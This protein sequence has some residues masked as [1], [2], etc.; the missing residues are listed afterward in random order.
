MA[1]GGLYTIKVTGLLDDSQIIRK[2]KAIEKRMGTMY[3]G[4]KGKNGAA[5]IGETGKAAEKTGKQ[6]KGAAKGVNTYAGSV[7]KAG[8]TQKRFG[9]TTLDIT[10]KVIQFGATTAVIRGVTSGMGDMVRQVFE[11][12]KSLTEFKKVSTLSGKALEDYTNQAYE[13]GKQTAKTGVEMLDAATQFKKMGYDEKTSLQLATTATMFQNIADAEISAGDAALF[14]NSQMKAFSGEFSRMSTEGEKAQKVIDSVNEVANNYAVGSNDLQQALTKTS[15]AM[16]TFGNSFDQ[17]LGIMTAGTEIMVGMPSQVARGWR[18]IAANISKAGEAGNTWSAAAGKVNITMKKQNGEIKNT[19]EFLKDLYK[20]QKGVSKGWNQLNKDE[21]TAIALELAGKNNQEKF[22]AVMNNFQTAID[23]TATSEKS[24]GSAMRENARYMES[25]EGHVQALQSAWSRFS[26]AMIKS[27]VLK[28]VLDGL[29]KVVDFLSTDTGATLVKTTAQL[30][31]LA[32]AIR[33][34]TG[35]GSL[36]LLPFKK[37]ISLFTKFGKA[38]KV[39]AAGATAVKGAEVGATAGAVGLANIFSKIGAI[40]TNP[41]GLIA[42]ML[43]LGAG[44][45]Y[46]N[47]KINQSKTPEAQ[48]EK[49]H[50]KLGQLQSKYDEVT[51][52]ID[53]LHKK[54]SEG[55]LTSSEEAQLNALESEREAIQENIELYKQLEK[56]QKTASARTPDT[57]V[58]KTDKVKGKQRPVTKASPLGAMEKQAQKDAGAVDLLS[59]K[60]VIYEDKVK[61]VAEA[62]QK[63][64]KARENAVKAAQSGDPN[65]M[66][67]A[68][69]KLTKALDEQEVA[70]KDVNKAFKDMNKTNKELKE[71]YGSQERMPD[72]IRKSSEAVDKMVA[73][74]KSF[75]K[76]KEK[77]GEKGVDFTGLSGAAL[78]KTIDDMKNLGD[79]IGITVDE[80]GKLQRVNF[81]TMSSSMQQMGYTAEETKSALKMLGEQHPEA[82]FEIEGVDVAGK[83]IDTVLEYLDK[84]DG[85]DAEA[86]MEINGS[87]VAVSDIKD[88]QTLM[89]IINGKTS[90]ASVDL[91]GGEESANQMETVTE[92]GEQF[93]GRTFSGTADVNAAPATAKI[94]QVNQ[95]EIKEKTGII[96]GNNNPFMK[97]VRGANAAKVNDKNATISASLSSGFWGVINKAKAALSSVG[98]AKGTPSADEGFAE[99]NELGYEYIRDVKTGNLRVANGGK[100]GVTYLNKGDTV[101]T[102]GQSL[103]MKQESKEPLPQFAK[104]KKGKKKAQEAYN[105]RRDKIREKYDNAVDDLEYKQDLKHL[106]DEWLAKK[107]QEKWNKY[108]K[109]LKKYN[110]SKK[111][112][113]WKKKY[114]GFKIA[115]SLGKKRK[116]DLKL[117]KENARYDAY[118]DAMERE[119]GDVGLGFDIDGERTAG[120][121]ASSGREDRY[122]E[123][124]EVKK[125]RERLRKLKNKHKISAEDYKKYMDDLYHAY[126]DSQMKMYEKDKITADEMKQI[127]K[128]Q[129]AEQRITWEEYYEALEDIEDREADKARDKIEE[130]LSSV[131]WLSQSLEDVANTINQVANEAE[132][133]SKEVHDY[134]RDL[135]QDNLD[136][137]MNLYQYGKEVYS[138]LKQAV[139]DYYHAG[140]LT[141]KEYYSAVQDLASEAMAKEQERLEEK[142]DKNNNTY[143]LARQYVER[144]I[145]LLEK[146]N[147]ELDE[148]NELIEL[149]NDLE[150]AKSRRVRIYREGVGF[151]YEQDREAIEEATKALEQYKK[152]QDSPELK[153]WKEILSLFE[154]QDTVAGMKELENLIGMT[155]GQAFG[156][157]GTSLYAWEQYLKEN[158]ATELGMSAL[159]R[160]LDKVEYYED[161]LSRL[162][163]SGQISES[164]ISAYIARNRYASGTLSTPAGFAR[165]AEQGYEIGVFGAGDAVIPHNLS[166]NLM[167]WGKMSPLEYANSTSGDSY[168]YQFDKLVLPNVQN[169]NDF[170]RELKNLPNRA[171]QFSGGRA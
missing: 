62:E 77:G 125:E 107:M 43:A 140:Y 126:V 7:E 1:G 4:G 25:L 118:T 167:E 115:K 10:K 142:Q 154:E 19:Y 171:L 129:V 55:G 40:L 46:V 120:R 35:V 69:E 97:A 78:D 80:S 42:G 11:L 33:L 90:V 144:Q 92:K 161:I 48:Y 139:E 74:Y 166:K 168:M 160:D 117:A 18:T 73:S 71:F 123:W 114:K 127:L 113:G 49:T 75:K 112:K 132:L 155:T 44:I 61:N 63:V 91:E 136:H 58:N 82:T 130:I 23:A 153:T 67:K 17:T 29:T 103:R 85:D 59:S 111:V 79:A 170:M 68:E 27:D 57:E 100:R 98:L 72:D 122:L 24:H 102:H 86:T 50:K 31:A 12:D 116:Q 5:Y 138:N 105:K 94:A 95:Q 164:E 65:K 106:S 83:D 150:K 147:E 41:A 21:K 60:M 131:D 121:Y 14:I 22:L 36:L 37:G 148:Q 162:D 96:Q 76:L 81:D 66:A 28:D 159:L 56:A 87:E 151:V 163:G 110:K 6:A 145:S 156:D 101:Y 47:T 108:T 9:A 38:G 52:A 84:V 104:G 157:L 64:A 3:V 109:R 146:Q 53:R 128:D 15:A 13:A 135:Y 137:M 134:M 165:V 169:A 54:Q 141:A 39:A 88:V 152:E 93:A 30:I 119:V 89:D 32:G 124:S 143:D 70:Q 8:K 20:G 51:N 149:Q 158:R 26:N 34:V 16:G 45:M 99:V 2:L 133:E